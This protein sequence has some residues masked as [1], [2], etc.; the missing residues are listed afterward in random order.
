MCTLLGV[1]L[2]SG[3]CLVNAYQVNGSNPN[4][5]PEKAQTFNLG[6]VAD[7][8]QVASV[9]LDW[10]RIQKE[11]DISSPSISSA[12]EQGL[13]AKIGPRYYIYTNLQNIAEREVQGVDIDGRLRFKGPPIGD[14][15]LRNMFTYYDT[16]KAR[17]TSGSEWANFLDTYATRRWR[18]VI[19]ANLDRGPWSFGAAW[20][21]VPGFY[22]SELP[23]DFAVSSR[24]VGTFEELD[25]QAQYRGFSGL[26][27]TAGIKNALDRM[28]C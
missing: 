14:L 16:I 17:S 7:M 23:K 22:D 10:L 28:P 21:T 12:I 13:F 26:E 2:V 9:S 3:T 19:T 5:K 4:L 25:L 8:G 1:P 27:L 18:N 24:R 6:V 20:K 15:S 11:D